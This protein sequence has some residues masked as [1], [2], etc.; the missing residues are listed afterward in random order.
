MSQQ[1]NKKTA[2]VFELLSK[3]GLLRQNQV[4][5]ASSPTKSA[6]SVN[7]SADISL[8]NA[9]GDIRPGIPTGYKQLD[10][11]LISQGWPTQ[12]LTEFLHGQPG[13]GEL[14]LL[15]PALAHLSQT[16]NRWIVWI[17]PPYIPY[18]P[19][20]AEA[21]IDLKKIL[22]VNPEDVTNQL[23][24]LEKALASSSC[25]V[26]MAWP[27]KVNYKQLRRLQVASKNGDCLGVLYRPERAADQPSPAEL[28]IR[29]RAAQDNSAVSDRS[30]LG[31]EIL[32]RKGGWA[33]G[34]FQLE[35]ND[36]L[37]QQ[38]PDFNELTVPHW[39]QYQSGLAYL[40]ASGQS[41][42]VHQ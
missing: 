29:I 12:G 16:Q 32:K 13:L 17:S 5:R 41:S 38:T 4:W 1:V 8:R 35:I 39:Q 3:Q 42:H 11:M 36:Q 31:L 18:A 30:V 2:E 6:L 15:H 37:N 40:E 27:S 28:R 33:T 21:G 14:R 24:A 22:I 9:Y 10:Q 19:A 25:S 34:Q 7:A 20:L 26:V 23:W